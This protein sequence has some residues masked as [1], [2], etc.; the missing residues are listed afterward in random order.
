MLR[1]KQITG[2]RQPLFC[3][4]VL[5]LFSK[6]NCLFR[7]YNF[8]NYI[9]YCTKILLFV[10]SRDNFEFVLFVCRFIHVEQ[11]SF[12]R[13]RD[14]DI[15]LKVKMVYCF[16]PNC[17]QRNEKKVKKFEVSLICVDLLVF[18]IFTTVCVC[19]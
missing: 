8:N 18:G 10:N 11:S 9:E 1:S 15:D 3:G 16:V 14:G 4:F 5:V 12:D 13:S 19:V 6:N 2:A 17:N 7:S